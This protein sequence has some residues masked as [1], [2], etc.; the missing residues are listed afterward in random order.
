M[1]ILMM[2][3]SIACAAAGQLLLKAGM[4][5]IGRVGRARGFRW[6]RGIR[7][8][9]AGLSLYGLSAALWLFV[10]SRAEL[11]YA[12][13]FLSLS[14]VAVLAGARWRLNERLGIHRLV[15]SALI[16][17]GVLAVSMS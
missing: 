3:L 11:S 5:Q 1:L 2:L 4:N 14:Y 10:L 15:G 16:V 7:A 9:T 12:F 17:L 6:Q 8:V 13:P